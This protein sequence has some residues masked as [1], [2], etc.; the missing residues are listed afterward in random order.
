MSRV[1]KVSRT[2]DMFIHMWAEAMVP[3]LTRD[4]ATAL[5]EYED[6]AKA[7]GSDRFL[8][9]KLEEMGLVTEHPS[10]FASEKHGTVY[11]TTDAGKYVL[12]RMRELGWLA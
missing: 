2:K 12:R 6:K 1:S 9:K 8:C 7:I 10:M 11:E 4:Q 3:E 5:I